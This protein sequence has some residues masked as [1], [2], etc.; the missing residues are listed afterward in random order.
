MV[1]TPVREEHHGL[2]HILVEDHEWAWRFALVLW[3]IAGSLFVAMAIP[4]VR[5]AIQ[6]MDEWVYDT[7]YPIKIAAITPIAHFLN[8]IGGGLFA[9]PLRAAVTLVLVGK[10]RWEAVAA[11]L[12]ALVLSEP[13]IWALKTLYGRERPPEALVEVASASFPSGHAIAGAVMAVGIVVAFVPAGPE[14]RNL[15]L[16]AAGFAFVMGGSRIYLGAHY[17][18]DV[19]AGVAFGAAA[20]VGAAVIVHRFFVRRFVQQRQSA[21]QRLKDRRRQRREAAS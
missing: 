5:D 6:T 21:Y 14:R 17:L 8:F 7:T 15:E 4:P 18:T 13:F 11:W 16:I 19:I 3:A 20:A 9:W 2:S 12:T 1:E 10:K